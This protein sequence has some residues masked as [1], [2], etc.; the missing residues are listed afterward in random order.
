MNAL[1]TAS[2]TGAILIAVIGLLRLLFARQVS[3]RV[4]LVLW[5]LAVVRLLL[6]ISLPSPTSIYNLPLF[7][8]EETEVQLPAPQQTAPVTVVEPVQP[9]PVGEQEPVVLP[10]VEETPALSLTQLLTIIWAAVGTGLFLTFELRHLIN[11]R[12]YRFS[13]PLPQGVSVPEGLRVRMLDGLSTPL[14][15]GIFRPT[16]LIPVRCTEQPEQLQHI[17]LHEQAHIRNWDLPKKHLF[18]LTACIHWFNP[19]V[20]LMVALAFEDMEVR[21]DAV[22]IRKLGTQEK[23]AYARTLVSAET[24]RLND[25]LLSNFS[26]STT[27][28]RLKAL[29]HLRHRPLISGLVCVV[30]VLALTLGFLTGPVAKAAP[31]APV[32]EQP[33]QTEMLSQQTEQDPSVPETEETYISVPENPVVPTI[34]VDRVDMDSMGTTGEKQVQR[35]PERPT[36]PETE[37]DQTDSGD[38]SYDQY[39]P[40]YYMRLATTKVNL[41]YAPTTVLDVGESTKFSL[42]TSHQGTF[43][44]DRPDLISM[45]SDFESL[46]PYVGCYQVTN[47]PS[48]C[49]LSARLKVTALAE[50][51]ATVYLRTNGITFT[52]FT[53]VITGEQTLVEVPPLN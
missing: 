10:P 29:I 27:A 36:E 39:D 40:Y 20:W 48:G 38:S 19:L 31:T 14:S 6:P 23:K 12:R 50:G 30:L 9:L 13:L 41:Y 32:V 28:R 33:A 53:I 37:A 44:T 11:R 2:I 21:C 22:A 26:Q 15:Y 5:L 49:L 35:V 7:S 42:Y 43:Y 17:L 3:R 47:Y 25:L 18:L 51:A 24:A 45:E 34:A 8:Q 4:F 52:L 1:L 46:F 16:V